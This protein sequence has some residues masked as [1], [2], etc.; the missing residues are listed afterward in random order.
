MNKKKNQIDNLVLKQSKATTN[1][2]VLDAKEE[3]NK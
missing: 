3:I 1:N 2:I